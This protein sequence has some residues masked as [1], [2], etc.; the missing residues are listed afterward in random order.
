MI[1]YILV[2]EFPGYTITSN[3][4]CLQEILLSLVLL[5]YIF[6]VVFIYC[7]SGIYTLKKG[8]ETVLL[9]VLLLVWVFHQIHEEIKLEKKKK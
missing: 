1:C 3:L 2:L 4:K 7:S 6:L 5:C 8:F 9:T